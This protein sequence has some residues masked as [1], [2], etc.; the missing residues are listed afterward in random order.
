MEEKHIQEASVLNQENEE[1]NSKVENLRK[2]LTEATQEL[3]TV[4][5]WGLQHK[6]YVRAH[7]YS[8]HFNAFSRKKSWNYW[9]YWNKRNYERRILRKMLGNLRKLSLRYIWAF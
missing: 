3:D 7:V 5:V 6:V 4:K 2:D 9:K 1:L 8:L